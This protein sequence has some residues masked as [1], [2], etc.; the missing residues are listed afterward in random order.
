M[1]REPERGGP[2][3]AEVEGLLAQHRGL[4]LLT[5]RRFFPRSQGDDDLLQCGLIGLWEAARTW[6]GAGAFPCYARR[7]ILNNMRDYLRAQQRAVPPPEVWRRDPS[8]SYEEEAIDR[9]DMLAR[10]R[11]A[12]PE[13]S[14]ER[15]VLLALLRGVS[16]QS[17]AAALG[18]Q[19]HTV[20]RIAV[21]AAARLR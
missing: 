9:L 6:R 19:L 8:E 3:A 15:Y 16:R 4:V 21:R 13:N 11:A 14:R 5:A 12:W 2:G 17:I 10:I 7:C 1:E 20:R 18:V